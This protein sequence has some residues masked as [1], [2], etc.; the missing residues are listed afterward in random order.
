[1]AVSNLPIFEQTPRIGGLTTQVSTANASRDG[2]TGTYEDIITGG[3]NGTRID[4]IDIS[5][6]VVTTDGVIRLFITPSGG[7]TPRLWKEILVQAITPSATVQVWSASI[8]CS[9]PGNRLVLPSGYIL[10]AST[11]NAQAFNVIAHG[12]DL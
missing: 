1:M 11:H 4:H 7:G 3:V 6:A 2:I 10:K 9:L 8:D 5:A 12:G